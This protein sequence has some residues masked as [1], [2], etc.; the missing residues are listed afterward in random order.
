MAQAAVVEWGR[1]AAIG[2]QHG[3]FSD[4]SVAM[5]HD[6]ED[7]SV[8]GKVQIGDAAIYLRPADLLVLGARM[9]QMGRSFIGCRWDVELGMCTSRTC[10][11]D[12]GPR[13]LGA[14]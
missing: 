10:R 13:H 12:P 3:V 6:T 14:H 4:I 7:G 9:G 5:Q 11:F 8:W 1:P 2:E